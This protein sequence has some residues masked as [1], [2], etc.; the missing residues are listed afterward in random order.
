MNQH[1]AHDI[2]KIV[3]ARFDQS[4]DLLTNKKLQK[5]LYYIEAWSL[6]YLG[7]ILKENF[8][9]WVHGP[10]IPSVYHEYSQFGYNPIS[11]HYEC[12]ETPEKFINNLKKEIGL[13]KKQNKLIMEVL[14]KYGAQILNTDY[15][16]LRLA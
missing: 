10:V 7:A 2:S 9:A 5:L 8:Q 16:L 14:E 6:V 4:G 12:G 3:I 11:Q 1:S 13:K 15:S